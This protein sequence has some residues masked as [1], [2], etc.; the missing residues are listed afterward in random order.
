MKMKENVLSGKKQYFFLLLYFSDVIAFA[1]SALIATGI[2]RFDVTDLFYTRYYLFSLLI[3]I[4]AY[5]NYGL[6]ND[7]RN[8]FDDSDLMNIMYANAITFL[9]L[10]C[11]I[12]MFDPNDFI[13]MSATIMIMI[14]SVLFTTLG[15]VVLNMIVLIARKKGY[16]VKRTIFF[17]DEK[18]ELLEK[19][20]DGDLGYNVI[21]ITTNIDELRRHLNDAEIV[22]I[23]MESINDNMLELMMKHDKINW[24]IVSSVLNLVIDPVAFDE[25][26]DY[27]IINISNE[28]TTKG[29]I[30]LKRVMDII[31]S[32]VSLIVLSPI[33]LIIAI[34]IK[35]TMPGPIFYKHERLGKNLK[36]FMLYKFRTMKVNADSEKHKLHNEVKGIFKMKNDPRITPLGK[37]LR[38]SC[39]DELPQLINIF[40]G[41][42]SMVGPRPHLRSE[43]ANF[44]GWRRIRFSV[45]PGLTGL[46]Q[47]N[48]RHELNFDKAVLYDIYYVKHMSFFLDMTIILKT[49]PSII[50]T[51]G[52]Y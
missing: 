42:M 1:L 10:L 15:R 34:I 18:D 43:L 25:F 3:L 40:L 9:I 17:G 4:I 33:F 13:L 19:I 49:I 8:L 12:V 14:S 20:S 38:R 2:L 35:I 48:G 31:M 52:R 26:K 5:S 27:P 6:Y 28:D 30:R 47:V 23:K 37:I 51:K 45:K 44:N 32:G 50:M 36:P 41:D 11:F 7:K 21:K 39:I 24:K 29:Y 46:W 16:D 22:F